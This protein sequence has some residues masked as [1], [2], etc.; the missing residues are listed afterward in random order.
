MLYVSYSSTKLQK[1]FFKVKEIN[2]ANNRRNLEVAYSSSVHPSDETT[3]Q[4]QPGLMPS[5]Q[6]HKT[7]E[8]RTPSSDTGFSMQKNWELTSMCCCKLLNF[9]VICNDRELIHVS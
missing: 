6:P 7:P 9:G 2:S 5:L 8:Q 1:N 4:P 3:P